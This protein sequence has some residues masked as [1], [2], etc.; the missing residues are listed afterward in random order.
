MQTIKRCYVIKTAPFV[1]KQWYVA[2]NIQ[3]IKK[4]VVNVGMHFSGKPNHLLWYIGSQHSRSLLWR[5]RNHEIDQHITTAAANV[6]Q[7]I[8]V[9]FSPPQK[10][11]MLVQNFF[12]I[13][14]LDTVSPVIKIRFIHFTFTLI[15]FGSTFAG[16]SLAMRQTRT[17]WGFWP[18]SSGPSLPL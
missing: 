9:V 18:K 3:S 4:Y 17:T 8:F 10:M 2:S 6:Q 12:C 13:S 5:D 16:W 14:S 15:L 1:Q 7:R 11:P